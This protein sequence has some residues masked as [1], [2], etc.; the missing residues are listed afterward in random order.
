MSAFGMCRDTGAVAQGSVMGYWVEV[1]FDAVVLDDENKL[2]VLF[3]V[4]DST[5]WIPRS[6]M[7]DEEYDVCSKSGTGTFEIPRWLAEKKDLV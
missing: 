1:E 3:E 7:R 6:Q 4:G 2:A 5:V